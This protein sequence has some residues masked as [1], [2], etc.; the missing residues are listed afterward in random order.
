METDPSNASDEPHALRA[1]LRAVFEPM[2]RLAVMR[3]VPYATLEEELARAV[4]RAALAAHPGVPAHRSV[5]RIATSTGINRREVTRLV[6]QPADQ[7]AQP[8]R[9]LAN[10][11][12]TH[13][14]TA[15]E[16]QDSAGLPRPLPRLGPSPSFEALAQ[17]VTRDVHARS[18][19]DELLRLRMAELDE[20]RDEVRL[21]TQ[22]FVPSGDQVRMLGFLADNVGDHLAAG[23]DNVLGDGRRHFEQAL[24]AEDLSE[25]SMQEVRRLVG[26]Q[27][28]ALMQALVPPLEK[29][30]EADASLPALQRR[31]VRIGLYAYEAPTDEARRAGASPVPPPPAAPRRRPRKT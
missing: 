28:Q 30:I 17:T 9:T 8:N 18:L 3:G 6:N 12:F 19:L 4:V 7:P 5:S 21:L 24:F 2:A 13:W 15:P 31:R 1:A 20:D 26:P 29:L 27:W 16:F 10:E 25:A 14:R 23:V 22:G 11:V